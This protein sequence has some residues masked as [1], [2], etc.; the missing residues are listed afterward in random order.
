M[1]TEI[2]GRKIYTLK[3]VAEGLGISYAT[4]KNWAASGKI[5]ATRVGR[6]YRIEEGEVLRL[7]S[8]D[9]NGSGAGKQ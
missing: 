2:A 3:E 6:S 5:R 7:L 9:D 8:G 4:A 1:P